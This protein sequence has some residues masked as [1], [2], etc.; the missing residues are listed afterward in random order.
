MSRSDC[1]HR[2]KQTIEIAAR[3]S[4]VLELVQLPGFEKTKSR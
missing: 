2:Q 3:V 1:A 4:S